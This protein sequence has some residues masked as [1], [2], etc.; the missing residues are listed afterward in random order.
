M[1]FSNQSHTR[2]AIICST[3]LNHGHA[4]HPQP[5]PN[6]MI[7][8]LAMC[9]CAYSMLVSIGGFHPRETIIDSS[10]LHPRE[11]YLGLGICIG[12]ELL[13]H[14]GC[15]HMVMPKASSPRQLPSVHPCSE[16]ILS[17]WA[18]TSVQSFPP[19]FTMWPA[20]AFPFWF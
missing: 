11:V 17:S 3:S 14:D 18:D 2:S 19:L 6:G 7:P 4:G 5:H 8:S 12:I 20:I 15:L 13:V 10:A 1:T 16:R 9:D